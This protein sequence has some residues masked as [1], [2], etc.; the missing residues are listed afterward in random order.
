MVVKEVQDSKK[1]LLKEWVKMLIQ[2]K[3]SLM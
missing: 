3:M 1:N 2:E